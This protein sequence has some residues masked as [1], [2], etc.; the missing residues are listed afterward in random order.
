[1]SRQPT[2]FDPTKPF[3]RAQ[4]RASGLQVAALRGPRFQKVFYDLYVSSGIAVT[5]CVRARAALQISPDGA[6]V[7]HHTAAQLWGACV[8]HHPETHVSVIAGNRSERRGV[9]AHAALRG[10]ELTTL[11]GLT[12]TTPEQTFLDLARELSLVD[13]VVL[14]DSLVRL[15]RT[16]PDALLR[17]ARQQHGRGAKLARRA[18]GYVRSGVDSPMESRLRMLIVLA[19]LPEPVVD[20]HLLDERGRVVMRF[21]LSYPELKLLVEYDG[22]QHAEDDAQWNRDVER[23]ELLDELGWRLLVV[24]A[25]DIYADPGRTLDRIDHALR[26]RG[27]AHLPGKLRPEW[28]QHFPVRAAR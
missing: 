22:R 12:I 17:M 21:D 9:R 14:G 25:N 28:R 18:A 23:R 3:T 10:S 8:P 19:G 20:F 4:A 15:G 2:P 1:M 5:P 24:R 13:L 6:F 11:D 7:S 27:A 26:S 16:T